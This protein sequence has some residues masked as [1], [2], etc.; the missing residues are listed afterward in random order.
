MTLTKMTWFHYKLYKRVTPFH[1][2]VQQIAITKSGNI[3]E[4][5]IKRKLFYRTNARFSLLN[6]PVAYLANE[7]ATS[8]EE[9]IK[10]FRYNDDLDYYKHIVPYVDG[11]VDPTPD[12]ILHFI[13]VTISKDTL[14]LDLGRHSNPLIQYF[15]DHWSGEESFYNSVISTRNEDVYNATQA[16]AEEAYSNGFD[17][18]VYRSVRTEQGARH[19]DLNIV[20]FS[21]SKVNRK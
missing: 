21:K 19:P 9:V 7:H 17:G 16:I 4:I 6:H 5:P 13:R 8:W 1:S 12:D 11:L 18:I 10:E 15:E 3:K 14:I 2:S 20:I